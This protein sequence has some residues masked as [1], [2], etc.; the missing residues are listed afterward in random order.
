[1]FQSPYRSVLLHHAN[2]PLSQLE[3]KFYLLKESDA[4]GRP[5]GCDYKTKML[6]TTVDGTEAW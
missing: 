2:N 6:P 3:D 1:M 5:L 4:D